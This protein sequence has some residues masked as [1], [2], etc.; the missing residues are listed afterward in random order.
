MTKANETTAKPHAHAKAADKTVA[1]TDLPRGKNQEALAK[2]E[3]ITQHKP[4]ISEGMAMSGG[5]ATLADVGKGSVTELAPAVRNAQSDSQS[6][7]V[8]QQGDEVV[9]HGR[10]IIDG[11]TSM[12]GLVLKVNQSGTIAARVIRTTGQTFDVPGEIHN[13]DLGDGSFYWTWPATETLDEQRKSA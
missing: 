11:Q 8:V 3:H 6:D 10:A 5:N 9:I 1:D 13:A 2:G 4:T 7:R 12:A